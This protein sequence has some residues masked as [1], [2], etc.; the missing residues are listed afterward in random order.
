MQKE[1]LN[2]FF[3][4]L[5]YER[6]YSKHTIKSY[7]RD[8][9]QFVVFL[10]DHLNREDIRCEDVDHYHIRAYLSS[11]HASHAK[12]SIA[13]KL[14]AIRSFF[15]Y[16]MK[17]GRLD[18]SPAD[19]IFG[20][21]LEKKTPVFL[22]VDEAFALMEAPRHIDSVGTPE[23]GDFGAFL[24]FGTADRRDGFLESRRY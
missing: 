1:L 22:T 24:F 15:K 16:A 10:K 19:L 5:T 9:Y 20:L 17:I 3:E 23:Q 6:G 8:L 14:A 11:L 2:K 18:H 21:K 12:S 4:Y 7:R 13:R